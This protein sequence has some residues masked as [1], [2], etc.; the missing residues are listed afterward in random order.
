MFKKLLKGFLYLVL[1]LLVIASCGTDDE[2]NNNDHEEKTEN[3]SSDKKTDET[4]EKSED[5]K[6]SKEEKSKE[7]S[8]SESSDSKKKPIIENATVR[9]AE[10]LNEEGQAVV[11]N[12]GSWT[13]GKDIKPGHYKLVST[14][15]SGNVSGDTKSDLN[16][17]LSDNPESD[18]MQLSQY[19]TY[20]FKGDEIEI[21]GL[22]GV[23]F[24]PITKGED[25]SNGNLKAGVY[26]VG[27]DIKPGRYKITAVKGSGNLSS[28]DGEINEILGT[29]TSDNMSVNEVT[30]N[31]REGDILTATLEEFNI[32][33]VK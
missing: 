5:T 10:K 6:T 29:D 11:L 9:G 20:L 14:G 24:T 26:V 13:V 7:S 2:D 32:T 33:P 23:S 28:D 25:V 21:S 16:I 15:G 18:Y 4:K 12:T 30:K 31:L 17:I 1:A 3:V 22:Q 19:S 8:H 27:S